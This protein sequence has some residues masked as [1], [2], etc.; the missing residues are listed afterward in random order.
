LTLWLIIMACLLAT[1][2]QNAQLYG[3]N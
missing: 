3:P 1:W 2:V